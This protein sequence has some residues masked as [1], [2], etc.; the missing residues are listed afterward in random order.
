[1]SY[2]NYNIN[3]C[4]TLVLAMVTK[5]QYLFNQK[6]TGDLTGSRRSFVFANVTN[7][8]YILLQILNT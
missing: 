5:E 3:I 8:I 7:I 2:T 6:F 1:M 4:I